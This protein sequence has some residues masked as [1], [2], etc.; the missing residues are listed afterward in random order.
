MLCQAPKSQRGKIDLRGLNTAS[1]R[2]HATIIAD[3]WLVFKPQNM[4]DPERK[5]RFV[6][7]GIVTT[8]PY[9]LSET[10]GCAHTYNK[11]SVHPEILKTFVSLLA[12]RFT[13]LC[14]VTMLH[15]SPINRPTFRSICSYYS[16]VKECTL[17]SDTFWYFACRPSKYRNGS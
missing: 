9:F 16:S 7:G 3:A 6:S 11:K 12:L 10:F 17:P 14:H 15:S 8:V 2:E 13:Y 4:S 5:F 1:L